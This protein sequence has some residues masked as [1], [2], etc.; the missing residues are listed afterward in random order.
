[1]YFCTSK[2]HIC[3]RFLWAVLSIV[4]ANYCCN[5]VTWPKKNLVAYKNRYLCSAFK[6]SGWL[7]F[8]WAKTT[9]TEVSWASLNAG[10]SLFRSAQWVVI[11][12]KAAASQ[13][14]FYF[15][16]NSRIPGETSGILYVSNSWAQNSHSIYLS[17][18]FLWPKKTTWPWPTL[19]VQGSRLSL[20]WYKPLLMHDKCHG[21]IIPV[22]R[23]RGKLIT[24][25]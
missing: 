18:T 25:V 10:C 7:W 13:G 19:V 5:H 6:S 8:G 17:P 24:I 16:V 14:M 23:G 20:L 22:D 1:M 4:S 21:F 11:I 12:L 15:M 3:L 2:L 9:L